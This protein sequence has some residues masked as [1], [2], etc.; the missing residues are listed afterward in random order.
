M[1][2]NDF[3]AD[4]SKLDCIANVKFIAFTRFEIVCHIPL[5]QSEYEPQLVAGARLL[6]FM[7][8]NSFAMIKPEIIILKHTGSNYFLTVLAKL[9]LFLSQLL[10]A[11]KLCFE[12][13]I[14][15]TMKYDYK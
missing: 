3:V 6:L 8:I 12:D 10:D 11:V 15:I 13:T 2:H 5:H 7:A 1:H 4:P 14:L 9:F